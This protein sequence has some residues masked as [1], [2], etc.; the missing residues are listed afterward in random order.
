GRAEEIVPL[1]KP[2]TRVIQLHGH[3][4]LPGLVDNH[5]HLIR[6]G[7]NFNMELRWDGVRSLSDAMDMLKRR[8]RRYSCCIFMTVPCS[9][10]PLCVRWVIRRTHRNHRG[11]RLRVTPPETP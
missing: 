1:A 9:M 2:G 7:L 4:V 6:G 10:R 8:R 11:V 3:Q 5:L